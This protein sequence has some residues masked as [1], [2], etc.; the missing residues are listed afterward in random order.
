MWFWN[1]GM[2]WWMLFG[3]LFMVL[4]WG[5]IIVLIVWVVKRLT[6]R[7]GSRGDTERA[8]PLSIAKERYARGEI[9]REQYEQI[10]QD[11]S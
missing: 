5:G 9:T 7:G 8:D 2:N 10:K 3:G 1:G 6:E 4:F 11:L